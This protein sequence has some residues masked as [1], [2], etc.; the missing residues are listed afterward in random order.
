M[1]AAVFPMANTSDKILT[2]FFSYF[3]TQLGLNIARS[4][5]NQNADETSTK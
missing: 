4:V 5:Q 3:S 2:R 1:T